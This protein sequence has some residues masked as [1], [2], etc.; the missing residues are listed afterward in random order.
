[1]LQESE[2]ITKASH[3]V[4]DLFAERL[5]ADLVYHTFEHSKSVAETAAKIAVGMELGE[6]GIEVVTLAGWLHDIGYTEIYAGH[7]EIS[8]RIA[9][10]FLERESYP[11][12]KIELIIGCIAATK[13]PQKPKNLLEQVIADADLAGLGRKSF[14][15]Q[16]DLLHI[17]WGTALS[18]YNTE[19][20]WHNQNIKLLASH[21]FFTSYAQQKYGKRQDE[22]LSEL[23]K[24]LR[25][26]ESKQE[27][28]AT[29]GS[30]I[31]EFR[32][33]T[34][35]AENNSQMIFKLVSSTL[36][37]E[38]LSADH[39][40][41]MLI[42]SNVVLLF[43][44]FIGLMVT[45]MGGPGAMALHLIFALMTLVTTMTIVLAIRVLRIR[46]LASEGNAA[47]QPSLFGD[48]SAM[49]YD[50]F[51]ERMKGSGAE[52]DFLLYSAMTR[53]YFDQR[54]LVARKYE[55]IRQSY[56]VFMTGVAMIVLLSLILLFIH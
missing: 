27:F 25:K 4:Q 17:E 5:S 1:M 53:D 31:P 29:M 42:L 11:Q 13:I 37:S 52:G 18:R 21:K 10:E 54:M 46:K 12:E 48:F 51:D 22:N 15:E 6:D 24:K 35:S 49:S 26:L 44:S 38:N 9:R 14:F 19:I 56:N 55:C 23:R 47:A 43:I 20:E 7:E 3:F 45:K 41:L 36:M 50:E 30:H 34:L 39:K 2:I 16:T 32:L 8:A 28:D 33:P 40:A